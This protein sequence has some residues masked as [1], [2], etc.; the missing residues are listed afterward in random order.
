MQPIQPIQIWYDYYS[1]AVSMQEKRTIGVG[2]G[3]KLFFISQKSY[4][5]RTPLQRGGM[6][7][8]W[9]YEGPIAQINTIRVLVSHG[10]NDPTE[11]D[12]FGESFLT[13]YHGGCEPYLWVS[14]QEEFQFDI[15][16][17][18][19]L[20]FHS[21]ASSF[22]SLFLFEGPNF[23][24]DGWE[25][26]VRR[27]LHLGSP[28]SPLIPGTVTP[29]DELLD[30]TDYAVDSGPLADEWLSLLASVSVD[31]EEYIAREKGLHTSGFVHSPKDEQEQEEW[32]RKRLIFEKGESKC[33]RIR[34]EWYYDVE[35]PAHLALNE[36]S[37]FGSRF[38]YPGLDWAY[39]WP[40]RLAEEHKNLRYPPP[41]STKERELYDSKMATLEAR[42]TRQ[43]F[44]RYQRSQYSP[45]QI[46]PSRSEKRCRVPGAWVEDP[47]QTP[48]TFRHRRRSSVPWWL[49]LLALAIAFLTSRSSLSPK[50]IS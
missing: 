4:F 18:G 41:S 38:L 5:F 49:Y 44:R 27:L 45:R 30:Y 26:V 28:L 6:C 23:Q 37:E 31:I 34:W 22:A 3:P 47:F 33:Q 14:K 32:V 11:Q 36:F 7:N 17:A 21:V 48:Y 16:Q 1:N 43:A 19:I 9:S 35:S 24:S 2:K 8:L 42:W 46:K 20:P 50:V 13:T 39:H 10:Q 29:L 15:V 25:S 40:F 12:D